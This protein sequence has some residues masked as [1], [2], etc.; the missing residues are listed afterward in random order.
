MRECSR[1]ERSLATASTTIRV[2]TR[3]R[4]NYKCKFYILVHTVF[5]HNTHKTFHCTLVT[6]TVCLR[7]MRTKQEIHCQAGLF[8]PAVTAN[9]VYKNSFAIVR[10]N[11]TPS[12]KIKMEI[13]PKYVDAA[14]LPIKWLPAGQWRPLVDTTNQNPKTKRPELRIGQ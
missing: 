12:I 2:G 4:V 8:L 10:P 7:R 3:R 14:V 1:S 11:F 13:Y 5:I 6:L 9:V